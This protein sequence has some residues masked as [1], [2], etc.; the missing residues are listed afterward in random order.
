[1]GERGR[2]AAPDHAHGTRSG[3]ILHYQR[4]TDPCI[5]CRHAD[6]VWKQ[7]YRQ[8]G[9]CAPGLGWPLLPGTAVASG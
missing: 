5:P 1:V 7:E 2:K 3:F 4:G 6:N 9:K 8:R